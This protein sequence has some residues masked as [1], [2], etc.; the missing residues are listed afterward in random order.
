M[1]GGRST[2][3]DV[4]EGTAIWESVDFSP[5]GNFSAH[6]ER[7]GPGEVLSRLTRSAGTIRHHRSPEPARA[8]RAGMVGCAILSATAALSGEMLSG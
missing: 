7:I 1:G 6:T 8:L 5:D 3:E 2:P 4:V